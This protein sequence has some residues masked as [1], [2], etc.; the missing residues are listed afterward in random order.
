MSPFS[1]QLQSFNRCF[2]CNYIF[3]QDTRSFFSSAGKKAKQ[4]A[5]KV[6]NKRGKVST[7]KSLS[8]HD[9]GTSRTKSKVSNGLCSIWER[10]LFVLSG[11][12]TSEVTEKRS[13]HITAPVWLNR[14]SCVS[15][16]SAIHIPIYLLLGMGRG[17]H[18]ISLKLVFI[19]IHGKISFV[20]NL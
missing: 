7:A 15:M 3:L 5:S 13:A 6:E 10:N 18:L 16:Y 19:A 12:S 8:K 1:S 9:V 17:G 2:N 14:L 4:G 20:M 11:N